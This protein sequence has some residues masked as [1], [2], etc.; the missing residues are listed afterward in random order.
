MGEGPTDGTP[1][2]SHLHH[3]RLNRPEQYLVLKT[4]SNQVLINEYTYKS[5]FGTILGF[6]DYG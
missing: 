4:I 3:Q 1:G 5:C 6:N 2:P